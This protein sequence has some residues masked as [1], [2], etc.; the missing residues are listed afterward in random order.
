MA[1]SSPFSAV[2]VYVGLATLC[3]FCYCAAALLLAMALFRTR[4]L[5]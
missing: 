3:A 1:A 4:E 2:W 5:A